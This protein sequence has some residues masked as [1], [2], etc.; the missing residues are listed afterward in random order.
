MKNKLCNLTV[1]KSATVIKNIS[2]GSIRRRLLDIGFAEGVKVKCLF[3]SPFGDPIAYKI[4]GAVIALRKEDSKKIIISD[5]GG[6]ACGI[7]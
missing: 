7:N 3:K 2:Q 1:G 4:K 6:D 5:S